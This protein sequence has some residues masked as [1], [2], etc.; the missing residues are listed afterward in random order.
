VRRRR[1]VAHC[2]CLALLVLIGEPTLLRFQ[3]LKLLLQLLD[4]V[5]R[6]SDD[7]CLVTL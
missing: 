6:P 3:G 7:R 1:R 2:C 5:Y 4:E